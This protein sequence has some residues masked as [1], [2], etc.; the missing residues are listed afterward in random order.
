M[1][2]VPWHD[3]ARAMR[4]AGFPV[5]DIIRT[6][7]RSRAEVYKVIKAEVPE[8]VKKADLVPEFREIARTSDEF[9]AASHCRAL[10]R[11]MRAP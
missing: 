7:G 8:W 10:L 6:V 9:A 2:A 11:E 5:Q 3:Q 1:S 4:E